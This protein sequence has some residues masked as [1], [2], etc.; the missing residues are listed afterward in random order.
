MKLELEKAQLEE[1]RRAIADMMAAL[2]KIKVNL[3]VR[4]KVK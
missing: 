4:K 1:K 2:S 3:S